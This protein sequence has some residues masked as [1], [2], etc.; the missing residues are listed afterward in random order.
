MP[1]SVAKRLGTGQDRNV[2]IYDDSITGNLDKSSRARLL[3]WGGARA[4]V[5]ANPWQGVGLGRFATT[6]DD[7]LDRPLPENHPRDAHNAYLLNAAE[8][9]LPGLAMMVLNLVWPLVLALYLYFSRHHPLDRGLALAFVGTVFAVVVSCLFGSRF[10]EDGVIGYYWVLAAML[11]V[12]KA[13]PR[14]EV[15]A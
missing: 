5:E 7:Y 12:L 2:E 13:L 4:M 11:V 8:L 3:L 14:E 1:D 10:S 15:G 6:V 9:G